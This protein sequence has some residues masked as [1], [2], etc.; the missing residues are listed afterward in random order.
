M[1]TDGVPYG[2]CFKGGLGWGLGIVIT[3]TWTLAQQE[4]R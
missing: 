1:L 2:K 3:N 4:I